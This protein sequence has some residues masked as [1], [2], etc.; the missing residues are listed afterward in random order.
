MTY[1]GGA[2]GGHAPN[3]D[4]TRRLGFLGTTGQ[5]LLFY[6]LATLEEVD[7]ISTLRFDVPDTSIQGSTHLVWTSD[8]QFLTAI[9]DSLWGFDIN[10]LA[11]GERIVPHGLKV[12]HAM[13]RTRSGRYVVYGG[14]DHPRL[15]EAREIGIYDTVTGQVRRV[16][17]P[18]TCWH[19]TVHPV[20]DV[21]YAVSFRVSPAEGS[22]W[23]RWGMAYQRQYAFEIDVEAGQ[24]TRHWSGEPDLPVHINSD[25][26]ISDSELIFC[27]GGSH[28]VVLI[29]LETMTRVRFIDEHPGALDAMA[30][31]RQSMR[32]LADC[33]TRVNP[34]T[35]AQLYVSSLRVSRGAL[36]DGIYA[37]QLS[38]DQTLLF[39][40]NRGQNHVTIYD[41][42][43]LTPRLRVQLPEQAE[44]SPGLPTSADPR[45]GLHHS[46]LIS[47]EPSTSPI[48]EA[49]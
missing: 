10:R 6:D 4:P 35:D 2:T 30:W 18:T 46:T 15:G 36:M 38:S 13:K 47:P 25:V 28:T 24:V 5:H 41:Y 37:T 1:F 17:L 39:T 23:R 48:K 12:P 8:T 3:A 40:A 19:L 34:F 22:D 16:A 7:R 49:P 33:L 32:T 9:G 42:P 20:L 27:T 14:M 21:C 29:D 11:K 26:T 31:S 45:L 43:A 44:V